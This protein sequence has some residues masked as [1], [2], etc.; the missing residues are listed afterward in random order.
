MCCLMTGVLKEARGLVPGDA[1][2]AAL[3]RAFYLMFHVLTQHVLR[4][5]HVLGPKLGADVTTERSTHQ[6]N[7]GGGSSSG[8]H[9]GWPQIGS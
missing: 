6:S 5:F 4:F 3:L 7:R 2:C 9:P 8:H 1:F